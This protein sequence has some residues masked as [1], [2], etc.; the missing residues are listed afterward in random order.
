MILI[1]SRALMLRA[2][3]LLMR[4][5]QDFDFVCTMPEFEA[6]FADNK[7]KLNPK[8]VYPENNKMIV[9]GSSNC[10]FEIVAPNTSS[11]MLVELVKADAIETS[12]GLVPSLD[13]LFA[14]KASHK[15]LKNSPHFWK[16]LADYHIL[17]RAGAKVRPE[18]E[19]FFKLRQK[20][21]YTYAHPKLNQ[22]K[23]GFFADDNIKY[24]YDHDTIHQSV[25]MFDG[26]PAYTRYMKDGAEVQCDK[27]KFFA[28]PREIQLAGVVEEAAVLAIER[29]L[30]AHPGIWT[31][32]FAWRFALSKVCSSITSGWF[33]EF[34]YES[35][36]DVL[37]LYPENYWEKFQ[38]DVE[39]G[40]VKKL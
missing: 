10:E 25:A 34:A 16:T 37:R 27:A 4:K 39:S 36:F 6:W 23:D 3:Q 38:K 14:I 21:T 28:C 31:P 7:D 11:A 15:Y 17:K 5:P 29:S 8:K 40:L 24:V 19:A 22:N 26:I 18:Y 12:F 2:P 35:A 13:M 33:R 32:K 20:E 1:G 30:V 9:E